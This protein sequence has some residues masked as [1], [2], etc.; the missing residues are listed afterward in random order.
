MWPDSVHGWLTLIASALGLLGTLTATVHSLLK[1]YKSTLIEATKKLAETDKLLEE[2]RVVNEAQAEA[3]EVS[4]KDRGESRDMIEHL[5]VAQQ[6]QMQIEID[7][8]AERSLTRGHITL[9][10]K[11]QLSPLWAAYQSN[12]WNHIQKG[13]V[14]A[15]LE[16]PV[17][18]EKK[19]SED[20]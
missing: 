11:A 5:T 18:P 2:Q 13:R 15:A 19:A 1:K 9:R 14:N 8:I 16:L 7:K 10:D 4:I 6:T 20:Q 3:I 12:H 17:I